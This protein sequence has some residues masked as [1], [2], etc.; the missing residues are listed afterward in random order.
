[1]LAGTTPSPV[2]CKNAFGAFLV[3]TLR[4]HH[5]LHPARCTTRPASPPAAPRSPRPSLAST[6]ASPVN[7]GD[8][9]AFTAHVAAPAGHAA[10]T[11]QL[12]DGAT[13]VGS[14]TAVDA[15]GN[16]TIS[17]SFATAGSHSVTA[18]FTGGC[19]QRRTSVS[20]PI[21]Y[22]VNQAPADGDHHR[23]VHLARHGDLA[24]TPVTLTAT[25]ADTH[26]AT[27]P[28]ARCSSPTAAPTSAARSPLAGGMAALTQT[29]A[30][31]AHSF[32][33]TFTPTNAASFAASASTSQAFT[34]THLRRRPASRPS[35]PPSPP[36]R[37]PSA[38]PTP[39]TSFCPRRC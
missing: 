31:G 33:A 2:V 32:T 7:T 5:R 28:P 25:V 6:P 36:A 17:T 13:A 21:V 8:S 4:R 35:R 24:S 34:V 20:A 16:A 27:K 3:G 14:P 23:A 11:V 26:P 18:A 15:S 39:A 37:S 9:V 1:M 30:A 19:G 10:G 12:M 38:S 29:Y 22:T